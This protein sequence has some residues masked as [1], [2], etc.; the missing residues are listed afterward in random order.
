MY[1]LLSKFASKELLETTNKIET[2]ILQSLH[3][4]YNTYYSS[5]AFEQFYVSLESRFYVYTSILFRFWTVETQLKINDTNKWFSGL[6][7]THVNTIITIET[8][9]ADSF[10]DFILQY[11]IH[12]YLVDFGVELPLTIKF[13]TISNPTQD[14]FRFISGKKNAW[15]SI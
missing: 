4:N 6:I 8:R 12:Y 11:M 3:N 5:V 13:Y 15:F 10:R 14:F 2:S 1:T 7:E 9:L